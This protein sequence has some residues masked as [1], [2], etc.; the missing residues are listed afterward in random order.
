M[1]LKTKIISFVIAIL[2]LTIGSISI[3][4]F[5]QMKTL[6]T[7]QL[8]DNLFNIAHSVSE[9]YLVKN[10]LVGRSDDLRQN[11]YTEIENIRLK[12]GVDFIVIMDMSGI[13]LT[14]PNKEK[15]GE[16][17][18]GGDEV[19]VLTKGEQYASTSKGSLGTSLRVFI[20]I[21]SNGKQIGAVSVGSSIDIIDHEIYSKIERFIPF[22]IVGLILGVISATFLATNIKKAI[23]GLEPKEIAWILKEKETI[24]ENV[25]E[26][27]LAVDEKGK[28]IL[29]NKEAAQILNLTQ[30]DI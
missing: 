5:I 25:K 18:E 1:K 3:L 2:V 9:D 28:L 7:N 27:I 15:I 21:L 16:K 12:T 4:S 17:F 23:F 19:R 30:K 6:L 13:R 10:Y 20:P 8:E 22:V 29:F 14:H 11:F 26:G 24:L